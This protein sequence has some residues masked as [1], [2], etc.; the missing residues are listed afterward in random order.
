MP[1]ADDPLDV[2]CTAAKAAI[3]MDGDDQA[4]GFAFALPVHEL[5][6]KEPP[7]FGQFFEAA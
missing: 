5:A 2:E 1:R 7:D 3:A 4:D 6:G